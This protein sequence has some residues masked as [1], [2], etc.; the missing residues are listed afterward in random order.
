MPFIQALAALLLFTATSF[1]QDPPDAPPDA[2]SG[3]A[4]PAA[5]P[6]APAAAPVPLDQQGV[7]TITIRGA[8]VQSV[9][10]SIVLNGNYDFVTSGEFAD[11]VNLS[12]TGVSIAEALDTLTGIT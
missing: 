9:I 5:A 3:G 2:P 12:L 7:V 11:T 8:P 10:E 1:A 4:A 6:A